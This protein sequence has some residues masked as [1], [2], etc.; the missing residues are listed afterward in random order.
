M[1]LISVLSE[2]VLAWYDGNCWLIACYIIF[3]KFPWGKKHLC[4]SKCENQLNNLLQFCY[5]LFT[6]DTVFSQKVLN[7][8]K[9]VKRKGSNLLDHLHLQSETWAIRGTFFQLHIDIW[10][11]EVCSYILYILVHRRKL[12]V[13]LACHWYQATMGMNKM[14]SF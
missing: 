12:W 3:L 13:L 8:L 11:T 1:S 2:S 14:W 6:Q 9:F 10:C 7:L 4:V 5:R